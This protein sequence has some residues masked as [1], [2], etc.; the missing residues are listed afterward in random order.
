MFTVVA[1]LNGGPGVFPGCTVG[2]DH[3]VFEQGARHVGKD[4]AGMGIANPTG[5]SPTGR[6]Y[7]QSNP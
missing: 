6:S 1:G 5:N 3:A 2:K 7:G 4:I